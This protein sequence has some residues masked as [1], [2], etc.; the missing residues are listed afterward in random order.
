MEVAAS[1]RG[2]AGHLEGERLGELDLDATHEEV[3]E[4]LGAQTSTP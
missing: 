1:A 4:E 2:L 3:T